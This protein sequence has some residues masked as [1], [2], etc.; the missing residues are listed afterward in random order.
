MNRNKKILMKLVAIASDM[1]Q[2]MS[3]F[4]LQEARICNFTEVTHTL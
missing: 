3:I 2:H 4:S 1:L